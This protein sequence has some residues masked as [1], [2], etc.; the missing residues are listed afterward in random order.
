MLFYAC[1]K[2][3]Q[4]DVLFVMFQTT[5]SSFFSMGAREKWK[6]SMYNNGSR[7]SGAVILSILDNISH[8]HALFLPIFILIETS[9]Q[10][11]AEAGG[12]WSFRH[13]L[14]DA[15]DRPGIGKNY[16]DEDASALPFI[17]R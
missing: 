9:G 10:L 3:R 8:S 2:Q 14:Y 6:A 11:F 7:V 17:A 13:Q 4:I 15:S 1:S 16:C 5:V 12:R